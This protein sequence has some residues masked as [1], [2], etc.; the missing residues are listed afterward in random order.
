MS[1]VTDSFEF[2]IEFF[3]YLGVDNYSPDFDFR[4]AT[5]LGG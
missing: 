2:K 3:R 1:D 5:K 4:G